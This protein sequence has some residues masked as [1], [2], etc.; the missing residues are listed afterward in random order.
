MPIGASTLPG[1]ACALLSCTPSRRRRRRHRSGR[2]RWRSVGGR[3][4]LTLELP[5]QP[6]LSWDVA[7]LAELAASQ[8]LYRE[9]G[10]PG[11]KMAKRPPADHCEAEPDAREPAV[12][13][14]NAQAASP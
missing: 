7:Q 11:G 1:R 3:A 9:P 12:P 2:S 6:T 13:V 4:V 8:R 10:I 5:D 14:P